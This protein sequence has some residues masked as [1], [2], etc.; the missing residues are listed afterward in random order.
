MTD[1]NDEGSPVAEHAYHTYRSHVIPPYVRLLWVGF[2]VFAIFY[3]LWF[4]F[5]SIQREFREDLTPTSA[6]P[7]HV[8][9]AEE[10]SQP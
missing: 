9:S 10:T 8:E 7:A 1:V 5:P 6:A 2:Y 3:V 4:L